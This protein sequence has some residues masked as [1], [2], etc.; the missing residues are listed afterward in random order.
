LD[1]R[2]LVGLALDLFIVAAFSG[3]VVVGKFWGLVV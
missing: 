2:S 1:F 3:L